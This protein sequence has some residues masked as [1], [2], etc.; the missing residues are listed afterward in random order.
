MFYCYHLDDDKV[1]D[2]CKKMY[3]MVKGLSNLESERRNLVTL[4][5]IGKDYAEVALPIKDL[6][7]K[8]VFD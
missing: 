3:P 7:K 6:L 8:W 5:G 4:L 1:F 2:L